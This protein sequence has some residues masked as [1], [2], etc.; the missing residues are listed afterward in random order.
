MLKSSF[1]LDFNKNNS[2]YFKLLQE[3][4]YDFKTKDIKI[5]L[6]NTNEGISAVIYANSVL[7][8]KIGTSAFIKSLEI[9]TKTLEV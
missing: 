1:L 7:E 2:L 8:L 4:D 9:I 3:E 6:D 5:K